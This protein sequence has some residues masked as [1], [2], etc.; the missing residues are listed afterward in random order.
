M[1]PTP[2]LL[3]GLHVHPQHSPT[4]ILCLQGRPLHLPPFLDSLKN[5]KWIFTLPCSKAIIESLCWWNQFTKLDCSC[6]LKPHQYSIPTSGQCLTS[7]GIGIIFSNNGMHGPS[8]RLEFDGRDIG[9][10]QVHCIGTHHTY[11]GGP[12]LSSLQCFHMQWQHWHHWHLWK[13]QSC[14]HPCTIPFVTYLIHC[15]NNIMIVPTYMAFTSNRRPN[16]CGILGPHTFKQFASSASPELSGFLQNLDHSW[17][18]CTS[19][20]SY[21]CGLVP[22]VLQPTAVRA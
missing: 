19:I 17:S 9:L 16:T 20:H 2:S 18:L 22:F 7:W 10:G 21:L 12:Q 3:E 1:W 6:S 13:G 14:Q 4:P 5:P 11:P 15:S 8:H